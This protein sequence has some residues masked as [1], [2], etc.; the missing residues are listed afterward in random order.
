MGQKEVHLFSPI[1]LLMSLTYTVVYSPLVAK[2]HGTKNGF[3]YG[4]INVSIL[5]SVVP[6]V[7][8]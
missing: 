7:S 6:S 2:L 3:H 1:L 4:L 8:G 5:L